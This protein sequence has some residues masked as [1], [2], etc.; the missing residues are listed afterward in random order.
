MTAI[1]D[2]NSGAPVLWSGSS[3]LK[4]RSTGWPICPQ[5]GPLRGANRTDQG[6]ETEKGK[7]HPSPYVEH[8]DL[9]PLIR[10]VFGG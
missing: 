2:E 4:T 8:Y 10:N 1:D 6:R 3:V 7:K 9:N 5:V